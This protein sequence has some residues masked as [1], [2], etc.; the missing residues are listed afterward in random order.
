MKNFRI[1]LLFIVLI[2]SILK[3]LEHVKL[4]IWKTATN[5]VVKYFPV[6]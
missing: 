6:L 4:L 2:S 1:F 5:N 3:D